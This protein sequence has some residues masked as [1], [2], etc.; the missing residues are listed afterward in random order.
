MV[1]TQESLLFRSGDPN[2][3]TSL[4]RGLEVLRSF[5]DGDGQ[6]TAGQICQRTELSRA[7]VRRCLYTLTEAGYVRREGERFQLDVKVLS[8][9]QPYYSKANSLPAIAQPFLE[10]L[11]EAIQE[12]CSLAVL[13]GDEVVYVARAATQ[14]IMTVSLG[15]GSR[16]PSNYTS[17]GR[18][19]LSALSRSELEHYLQSNPLERHTPKSIVHKREWIKA[20]ESI[21]ESGYAIVDQE[22]EIGLRS[23][24]VPIRAE[25]STVV[26]AMNVG[27][28]ANRVSNAQLRSRILPPLQRTV[29]RL[30]DR[31][32]QIPGSAR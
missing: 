30:S 31:L 12:S 19:L 5:S 25:N 3:M 20:I 9:A 24:A 16:L 11:S 14:R 29:A 8:L 26:A 15:I 28:N 7:V 4:V 27:V 21:S 18:A 23:I 6:L 2:F 32:Q 22:L 17:L 10:G 13:D 1:T